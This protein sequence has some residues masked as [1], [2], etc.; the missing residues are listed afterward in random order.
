MSFVCVLHFVFSP[1][2]L[3]NAQLTVAWLI[4]PRG[5]DPQ[6]AKVLMLS[7]CVAVWRKAPFFTFKKNGHASGPDGGNKMIWRLQTFPKS[8]LPKSVQCLEHEPNLN[9]NLR[10]SA[11]LVRIHLLENFTRIQKF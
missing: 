5:R 2:D 11:K 1:S 7:C 10:L 8:V 4:C 9:F 3:G 6:G